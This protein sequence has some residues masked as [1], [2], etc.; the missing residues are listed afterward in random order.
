MSA[1]VLYLVFAL[2]FNFFY[3]KDILIKLVKNLFTFVI[4]S[5]VFLHHAHIYYLF[6]FLFYLAFMI[7]SFLSYIK[8][9]KKKKQKKHLRTYV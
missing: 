5:V 3:L 1:V 6:Y 4:I 9:Y 7:L 8:K 2:R